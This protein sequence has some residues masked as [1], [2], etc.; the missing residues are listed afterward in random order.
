MQI[1]DLLGLGFPSRLVETWQ[2]AGMNDLLP[3]QTEA[4]SSF[5]LLDRNAGNLLIVAPTSSGKT[6]IGE[7][8]AVREALDRRKSIFLVPFRAIAEELYTALRGKYEKYGLR[9]A[10]SDSDHREHDDDILS[11][12]YDIAVVVYEKLAGLLVTDPDLLNSTGLIV[13]DEI[14]MIMDPGRGPSIE[15]LLTKILN[16]RSGTRIIGLSAV[17]DKLNQFDAWMGARVLLHRFRPVELREAIYSKTGEVE[18]REFNSGTKGTVKLPPWREEDEA[19]THLIERILVSGEQVLVFCAT[20]G[21]AVAVA[22][23]IASSLKAPT[24]AIDTI[25][26]ADSLPDSS[27]KDDLLA[28]LHAG[29]AYHDSDLTLEERLL[30]EDGFRRHDVRVLTSTSTLSM[31]VNLPAGNVVI[32]E[33]KK[34]NGS[35]F[36]PISVGDY[37]NMAGRAGRYAAANLYGTSYLLASSDSD[38]DSLRLA[39]VAGHLEGFESAFG[40]RVIAE[41]VLDIVAG[42][43][44]DSPQA[45]SEFIF[46]TFNGRFR[47][48]TPQAKSAIQ[49]MVEESIVAC[50]DAKALISGPKGG[51]RVTPVGRVCASG[52]FSL[53]HLESATEFLSTLNAATEI[54][55]LYW[56]LSLDYNSD[57][58]AYFISK[59]RGDDYRAGTYQRMLVDLLT[60]TSLGPAL[61]RLAEN[62][63]HIQYDDAVVLRRALACY[64]WISAVPGSKIVDSFPSISMGAIRNTA[65]VC[66]RLIGFLHEIARIGGGADNVLEPLRTLCERL[67][68]GATPDELP[69]ARVPHSGLS[70]DE[71]SH[72]VKAGIGSVDE[73][74]DKKP[75]DVPLS[76][77]K[78][79]RLIAAIEESISDEQERRRRSQRARLNAINVD[80]A[81]LLALYS[82]TGKELERAINDV[83]KAPFL[84]LE[85]RPVAH[86][87]E[88]EP[89]HIIYTSD[90]KAIAV[91]TTARER[92]RVTMTKATSVIGQSAKYR[93]VAYIVFGRPDF[94]DL[95]IRDSVEQVGAG[96]NYKLIPLHALAEMHTLFYE[97]KLTCDDVERVFTKETGYIDLHRIRSLQGSDTQSGSS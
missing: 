13:A 62:P 66:V 58:A 73:L 85:C 21:S 9:I 33:P 54:D 92:R 51:L 4:I 79:L 1:T 23:R 18:Y 53:T 27:E 82:K 39:Y 44:A 22:H 77:A 12:D 72:L 14:Q 37:K 24:A 47:W 5:G 11:G 17:L 60:R 91:Q 88:G 49:Y 45:I 68:Y 64:A 30:V 16:Q 10:I 78:A 90:G 74:L 40:D 84:M 46:G 63:S 25:R 20:R 55:V 65:T 59:P 69:L 15:L 35:K 48:T 52:G 83:L 89:D 2:A 36:V 95:T 57:N 61:H 76:R 8:A 97:G 26:A 56:A 31:G 3:V 93:P 81:Q 38:A 94:D 28:L 42:Q 41:Q 19:L 96:L 50:S 70:R 32:L 71:R 86:Q 75:E 6:F 29:I 43:F 7:I 80:T 67:R 87:N 34:W